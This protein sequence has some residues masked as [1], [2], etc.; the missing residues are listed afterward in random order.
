MHNLHMSNV[1]NFVII[2]SFIG[3]AGLHV[4][5]F[6]ISLNNLGFKFNLVYNIRFLKKCNM[7]TRPKT[8]ILEILVYKINPDIKVWNLYTFQV[9]CKAIFTKILLLWYLVLFCILNFQFGYCDCKISFGTIKI[10]FKVLAAENVSK[11]LKVYRC[12]C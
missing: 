3:Y 12:V 1:Q 9:Y 8:T 4:I 6:W 2:S 7:K 10:F 11:K 5:Y